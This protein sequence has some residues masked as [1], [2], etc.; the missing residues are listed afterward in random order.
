MTFACDEWTSGVMASHDG[1]LNQIKMIMQLAYVICMEP[2]L[3][4]YNLIHKQF[5]LLYIQANMN[6]TML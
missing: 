2:L 3:Y 1:N 5:M 4:N 6:A